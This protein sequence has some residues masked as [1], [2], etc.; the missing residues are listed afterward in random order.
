MNKSSANSAVLK[1]TLFSL[2]VILLSFASISA[3]KTEHYNSPLYSP[4]T[5]DPNQTSSNGLPEVL[6]EIGIDQKL[7]EQLPLDAEFKD[8]A[9][10]AVKL[11]DFFNKEKPVVLAFVYYECPM[12]CNQVLN[13]LTGS[14]KGISFDAGKEFDVVA[15]SFDARENDKAGLAQNK[16]ISYMER[17]GRPETEKGWHFLTG[18]QE[19]ID[20]VTSAAG[21]K[22]KWDEQSNQF[23]HGSA[24]MVV[25]PEGKLSRYH[26][27]IDYAPKDL[28]FS[29]MDSAK[30]N[31]GNPVEQLSLYCFHYDPS[32]GKYGLAILRVLRLFAIATL[33]GL[34][35]M[36]FVFWR[37]KS[38]KQEM[39]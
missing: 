15:I 6:K 29:L 20:K 10:N 31:I 8:E 4:K 12:L 16:K 34:G 24:V 5:Y 7:G 27:G 38:R 2:A 36:L 37:R 32:T 11:G 14:L 13:G 19:S 18:S 23:A 26:Y 9:G 30:L 1:L 25:T 33:I 28:K 21:F 17:Y 39:N 22:Y 3:Q 35:G